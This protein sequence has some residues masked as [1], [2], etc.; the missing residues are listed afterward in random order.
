MS[1]NPRECK[2]CNC[3]DFFF[4]HFRRCCRKSVRILDSW[5]ENGS[6]ISHEAFRL[7]EIKV[8][9]L[10][11][12]QTKGL[13]ID[14]L[15]FFTNFAFLKKEFWNSVCVCFAFRI[16]LFI[17]SRILLP[18]FWIKHKF[19][20]SPSSLDMHVQFLL[21]FNHDDQRSKMWI[22][23]FLTGSSYLFLIVLYSQ[24][25]SCT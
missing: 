10:P 16:A 22:L 4:V 7:Q 23:I 6:V 13:S 1:P 2:A 3:S 25:P 15:P 11:R 14:R 9:V 12:K 18:H 5:A 21:L 19:L 20:W 17:R 8:P 24:I